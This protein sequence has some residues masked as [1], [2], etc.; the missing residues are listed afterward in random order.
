MEDKVKAIWFLGT[1]LILVGILW[2]YENVM[3]KRQIQPI[4]Q[5]CQERGYK[6]FA[7]VERWSYESEEVLS[8][9]CYNKDKEYVFVESIPVYNE[10]FNKPR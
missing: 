3:D 1:V 5:F 7:G 9:M 2:T 4:D 8:I 10:I 6:E